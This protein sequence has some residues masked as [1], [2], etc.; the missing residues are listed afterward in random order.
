[1]RSSSMSDIEH[2]RQHANIPLRY[3]DAKFEAKNDNQKELV[4]AIRENVSG[5]PIG[6]VSDMLI[7]GSVGTGKTYVVIGALNTLIKAGVYCRY[8]T[9]YEL[10]E[11]YFRKEYI[12]FDGFRQAKFLVIDELGKR[13][14]VDWQKIQIEELISYRYNEMLPTIFITNLNTKEFK[15]FVGDRVSDRMRDNS[16]IRV[17]LTGESMRGEKR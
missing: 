8:A 12:K 9:E 11:L 3:K 14:L 15:A 1:M 10:L 4:A 6:D 16:V 7:V 5:K 13:E 2:I 17:S